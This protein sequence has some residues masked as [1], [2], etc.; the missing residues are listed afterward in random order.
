[1]H[2]RKLIFQKTI[3]NL[4]NI[5]HKQQQQQ[6]NLQFSIMPGDVILPI[7]KRRASLPLVN[8]PPNND[9]PN[10]LRF[11]QSERRGKKQIVVLQDYNE[12]RFCNN[13]ILPNVAFLSKLAKFASD[14]EQAGS[15]FRKSLDEK[16]LAINLAYQSMCE[17][18][19][20]TKLFD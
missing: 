14:F 11:K 12:C 8:K 1:L 17:N 6:E 19:K 5:I 2:Q 18:N 20:N 4:K 3:K 10:P 13:S 9:C 16:I 7:S 15:P